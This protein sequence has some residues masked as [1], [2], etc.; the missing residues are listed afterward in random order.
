MFLKRFLHATEFVSSMGV[1]CFFK[2]FRKT[3]WY[4]FGTHVA[5]AKNMRA[6]TV[7]VPTL[8]LQK[9]GINTI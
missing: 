2:C 3:T 7:S 1:K 5:A 8:P 9:A 6:A 4:N